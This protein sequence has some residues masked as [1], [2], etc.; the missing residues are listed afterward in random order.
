MKASAAALLT[1]RP[2]AGY[3]YRAVPLQ[4]YRTL[5]AFHQ[6]M[7][8]SSRFGAGDSRNPYALL[9]LSEN[10]HVALLET[11]ALIGSTQ[12]GHI[13]F[14]NPQHSWA[15]ITVRVRLAAIADLTA[16]SQRKLLRTTVQELTG[17]WMG[18]RRRRAQSPTQFPFTEVPTQRLGAALASV[19]G[20]EGF[21]TWS[22]RDS[23]LKNLV[24]FPDKL[25]SGSTITFVNP[26]TGKVD[27]IGP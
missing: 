1:T 10:H 7:T 17:D 21:L 14:P 22:A 24:V 13:L 9:Y 20:L 3:W 2:H 15:I 11:E 16:G 4:H 25:R 27:R 18:Y 12:P 23:S 26:I 6:T 19:P 5:L 8:A